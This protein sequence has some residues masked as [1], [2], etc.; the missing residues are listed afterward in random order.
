MALKSTLISNGPPK[1]SL[2]K[3]LYQ[4]QAAQLSYY[5]YVWREGHSKCRDFPCLWRINCRRRFYIF[6]SISGIILCA[7]KNSSWA[8]EKSQRWRMSFIC[9]FAF[10]F[11][12]SFVV[13][14]SKCIRCFGRRTRKTTENIFSIFRFPFFSFFSN[15]IAFRRACGSASCLICAYIRITKRDLSSAHF[16]HLSFEF[17]KCSGCVRNSIMEKT[18]GTTRKLTGS[19]RRRKRS[20]FNTFWNTEHEK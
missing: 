7:R 10:S 16:L 20:K 12:I 15:C 1:S 19:G 11:Q 18:N 6:H 2:L 17:V 14:K 5:F 9:V 8:N 3:H 13:V 4:Y